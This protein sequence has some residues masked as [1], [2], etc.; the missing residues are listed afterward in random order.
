MCQFV[1][2]NIELYFSLC[3]SL[4]VNLRFVTT[5]L[6]QCDCLSKWVMQDQCLGNVGGRRGDRGVERGVMNSAEVAEL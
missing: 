2:M 6:M 1:S 5:N 4:C 3:L